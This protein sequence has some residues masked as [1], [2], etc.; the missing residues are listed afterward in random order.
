MSRFII[1]VVAVL[2]TAGSALAS[3]V[4]AA[5]AA[6][7]KASYIV[8]LKAGSSAS[9]D[10][11]SAHARY[12]ATV[13]HTYTHIFSGYA[14]MMT[15]SDATALRAEPAVSAVVADGKVHAAGCTG[16]VCAIPQITTRAVR[17]IGG[18]QSSAKSGN[19]KGTVPVNVAVL[20]TGVQVDHPDLNVVGGVD[21]A[22][23]G[24]P[25][26]SDVFGHGTFVGGL[27]GAKDNSF[28]IVGIAPGAHLWS[29]R[30]LDANDE[31]E[32]SN[33]LCGLDWVAGTRT[34]KNPNNDI[35]VANM[36]LEGPLEAR[37]DGHCGKVVIDPIH[38]AVCKVTQAGV[39]LVTAAGNDSADFA[40]N[41]PAAYPEVLTMTGMVDSDGLP[42]GLGGPDLCLQ[43]ADDT[44]AF[45]SNFAVSQADQAHALAAPA[46]C[47]SSDYFGSDVATDSGTSFASPLG[48]GTV[49]L[50]IADGPCGGLSAKATIRKVINDTTRYNT[51]NPTWGFQGDPL[52]P[53]I[54]KYYGWLLQAGLY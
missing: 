47:D 32:D 10:A 21:C 12:G 2:V 28:G 34:D 50:C 35:A 17:R 33:L 5:A 1:G 45:F 4:P 42:G 38:Q 13:K 48:A 20:D 24:N 22:N 3:V 14:A 46:V 19:G 53:V 15:A 51:K 7:P 26:F 6:S 40:G 11:A 9:A 39:P 43:Q 30:V 25:T 52:R 16:P 49:A 44:P 41:F 8:V 23:D 36:S 54:G 37:L 31:G 27:I 29:V 18:E